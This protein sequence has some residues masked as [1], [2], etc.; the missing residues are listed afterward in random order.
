MVRE[1]GEPLAVW[2]D[3]DNT[4]ENFL[5]AVANAARWQCVYVRFGG[6]G[7]QLG[8]EQPMGELHTT[9]YCAIFLPTNIRR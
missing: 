3:H 9:P 2:L 1:G 7:K 4:R 6:G 8:A 5:A